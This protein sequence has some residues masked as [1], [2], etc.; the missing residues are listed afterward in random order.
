MREFLIDFSLENPIAEDIEIGQIGELDASELIIRPS[1]EFLNSGCQYIRVAFLS[2][3]EVSYSDRYEMS[4][5]FRVKL[6][7]KWTQGHQLCLQLEGYKEDGSMIYK[8]PMVTK[9]CF[10]MSVTN[11]KV[12]L[13]DVT[14]DEDKGY[15]QAQFESNTAAR[16]KHENKAL[17]DELDYVDG[18]LHCHGTSVCRHPEEKSIVMIMADGLFDAST[19]TPATNFMSFVSYSDEKDFPIPVGSDIKKI[20][21]HLG[22]SEVPE[23]IA[24][25]DMLIVDS[26]V[27]YI[28][29]YHKVYY[30][31]TDGMIYFGSVYFPNEYNSIAEAVSAFVLEKIRVTY[32]EPE[33]N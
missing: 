32:I 4:E 8:S 2:Q 3:S 5:E 29:N 26:T 28:L 22:N 10:G 18:R 20:E 30:N 17:L 14:K 31:E 23:W 15:F 33:G 6:D 21:L 12:L 13:D 16:H 25:D 1:A 9:L 7:S 19:N 24:L 27:P 11:E